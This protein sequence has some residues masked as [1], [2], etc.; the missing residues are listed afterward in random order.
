MPF[1]R[2]DLIAWRKQRLIGTM[3]YL[4][5]LIKTGSRYLLVGNGAGFIAVATTITNSKPNTELVQ[6]F[7]FVG[8]K[9]ISK[10]LVLAIALV[11]FALGLCVSFFLQSI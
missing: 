1:D 2:D 7:F 8:D 9:C 4:R 11:F 6:C 3:D 10:G 5:N